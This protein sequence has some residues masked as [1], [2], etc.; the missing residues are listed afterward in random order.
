MWPLMLCVTV[1]DD[2]AVTVKVLKVWTPE[3]ITVIILKYE[4]YRFTT[5]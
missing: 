5:Q 2:I 1:Q 3:K 4:Q